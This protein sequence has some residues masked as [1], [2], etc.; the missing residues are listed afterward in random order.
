MADLAFIIFFVGFGGIF[1]F[2]LYY[3]FFGSK[4]CPHCRERCPKKATTC[5]RCSRD[6]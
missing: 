1:A 5:F 2:I 6:I 3:F 4:K